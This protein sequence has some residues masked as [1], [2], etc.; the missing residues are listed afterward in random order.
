VYT[1]QKQMLQQATIMAVWPNA[2]VGGVDV[3]V[4]D[5]CVRVYVY[6]WALSAFPW[7]S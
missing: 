4:C 2:C 6:I 1:D 5:M 7:T 3:T